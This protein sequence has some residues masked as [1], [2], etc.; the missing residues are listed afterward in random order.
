MHTK[1][2]AITFLIDI[3]NTLIGLVDINYT[4]KTVIS[5]YI[6]GHIE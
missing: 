6:S 4:I 3:G 2:Y 1:M 5:G